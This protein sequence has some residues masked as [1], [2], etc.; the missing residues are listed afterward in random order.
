MPF[1]TDFL[2]VHPY[3]KKNSYF[4]NPSVAKI[5]TEQKFKKQEADLSMEQLIGAQQQFSVEG[6]TAR[7]E[8]L[9]NSNVFHGLRRRVNK[10]EHFIRSI[11]KARI[12]DFDLN[13]IYLINKCMKTILD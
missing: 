2:V 7:I 12:G 13:H 6:E 1:F 3:N 11:D 9:S 4:Y 10:K 5:E 8:F